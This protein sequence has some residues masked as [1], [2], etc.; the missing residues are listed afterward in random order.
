MAMGER[1]VS[2][3]ALEECNPPQK[4]LKSDKGRPRDRKGS[5][6]YAMLCHSLR[7]FALDHLVGKRVEHFNTLCANMKEDALGHVLCLQY[8]G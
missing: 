3:C 1:Y 6:A 5:D 2:R 4:I 7:F 8:L